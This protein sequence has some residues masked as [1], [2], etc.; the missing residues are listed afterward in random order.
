MNPLAV[1]AVNAGLIDKVLLNE[2]KRWKTPIEIP[3]D[4]PDPPTTME[5]AAAAIEQVLQSDVF[6]LT[7]ETD[8][9]M[10]RQYMKTQT[11]GSLHVEIAANPNEPLGLEVTVADV[12]VT[13]GRTTIGEYIILWRTESIRDEMTN[14][15]T[16][17]QEGASRIFFKD[18]REVFYGDA[19]AFMVCSP[20][21]VESP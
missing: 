17:L 16:Y 10:F 20:S 14:G 12:T 21:S 5:E 1:A 19:K 4:L 13:Y 3:D 15:M 2:F 9:E 6:V 7:R 8:L 18:V 11:V